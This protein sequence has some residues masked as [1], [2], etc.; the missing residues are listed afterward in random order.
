MLI[1]LKISSNIDN[2]TARSILRFDT[3][4]RDIS[5]PAPFTNGLLY[6]TDS[7]NLLV[8][9][10]PLQKRSTHRHSCAYTISMHVKEVTCIRG[11]CIKLELNN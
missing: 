11:I 10:M 3:P 8:I 9:T 1:L 2:S 5:A 7:S 6:K 4:A